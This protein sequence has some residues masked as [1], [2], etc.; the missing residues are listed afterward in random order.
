MVRKK[1]KYCTGIKCEAGF[2]TLSRQE[3]IYTGPDK[4]LNT[5]FYLGFF[6]WGRSP[7]WPKATSSVLGGPGDMLPKIF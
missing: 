3:P 5:R 4:F 7:E 1:P 2:S 6:V